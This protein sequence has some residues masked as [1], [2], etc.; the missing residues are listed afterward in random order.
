MTIL[1]HQQIYRGFWM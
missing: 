1:Q